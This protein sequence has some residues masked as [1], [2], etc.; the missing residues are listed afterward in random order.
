MRRDGKKGVMYL[1][2]DKQKIRCLQ[3]FFQFAIYNFNECYRIFGGKIGYPG[4]IFQSCVLSRITY[5][6]I[7][8]RIGN[9]AFKLF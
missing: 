9:F 7:F 1:F 3:I 2:P 5:G 6:I 4:S 8:F